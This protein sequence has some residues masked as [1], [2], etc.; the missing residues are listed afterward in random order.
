MHYK[1]T[2]KHRQITFIVRNVQSLG[3]SAAAEEEIVTRLVSK[4]GKPHDGN[5][6]WWRHEIRRAQGRRKNEHQRK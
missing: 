5:T 4:Y 1:I 6:D 2:D 3:K